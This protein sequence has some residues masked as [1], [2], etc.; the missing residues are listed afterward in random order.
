MNLFSRI[1]PE[2]LA[3][4]LSD[5]LKKEKVL[6]QRDASDV[7]RDVVAKTEARLDDHLYEVLQLLLFIPF[8]LIAVFP[9][10][11]LAGIFSLLP[12]L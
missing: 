9:L 4:I 12:T 2:V 7:L 10:D 3:N 11:D 1:I 8:T 6:S 5:S